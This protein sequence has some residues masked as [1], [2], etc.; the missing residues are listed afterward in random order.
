MKELEHIHNKAIFDACNEALNYYRPYYA[1]IYLKN[2]IYKILEHL[3][4]GNRRIVVNSRQRI[5][6]VKLL[7][8]WKRR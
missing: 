2:I 4:L 7:V 5:V 6:F 3:I 8:R 1:S